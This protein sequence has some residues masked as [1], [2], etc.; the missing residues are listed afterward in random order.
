MWCVPQSFNH[1]CPGPGGDYCIAFGRRPAST[2]QQQPTTVRVPCRSAPRRERRERARAPA[3]SC[4]QCAALRKF[5]HV[6][7]SRG[8][9]KR[10]SD[11]HLIAFPWL[12]RR[13]RPP[14]W[15]CSCSRDLNASKPL[16]AST[17]PKRRVD[18]SCNNTQQSVGKPHDAKK[19]SPTT[20]KNAPA[21]PSRTRLR[22]EERAT[23]AG[24]VTRHGRG[25]VGRPS[26]RDGD[27]ERRR[28]RSRPPAKMAP[29]PERVAKK[30]LG[31][32]GRGGR[33]RGPFHA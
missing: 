13:R 25:I 16:P 5:G 23:A 4:G 18:A 10:G 2:T 28:R 22:K 1:V 20:N 29:S 15:C 7:Q 8:Q 9:A 14:P 27:E 11:H 33:R 32:G 19:K 17:W 3:A 31:G 30:F 21:R 26:L 6:G 24:G 12:V